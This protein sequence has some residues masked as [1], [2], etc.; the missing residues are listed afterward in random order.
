MQ[1]STGYMK[2]LVENGVMIRKSA[3][4]QHTVCFVTCWEQTE[5]ELKQTNKQTDRQTKTALGP[6]KN[7]SK[8]CVQTESDPGQVKLSVLDVNVLLTDGQSLY[9]G[10]VSTSQMLE[11]ISTSS[12][13]PRPAQLLVHWHNKCALRQAGE[14]SFLP[15]INRKREHSFLP[16]INRKREHSFPPVINNKKRTLLSACNQQKKRGSSTWEYTASHH[17]YIMS[18]PF[19]AG[20][21]AQPCNFLWHCTCSAETKVA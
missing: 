8:P 21:S 19:W 13:P 2:H 10:S 18:W 16:V 1:E 20:L 17:P 15:V 7:S 11:S 4:I 12:A 9:R 3:S 5:L 6:M 14:H